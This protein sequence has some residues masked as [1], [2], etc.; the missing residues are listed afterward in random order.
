MI[1]KAS[2]SLLHQILTVCISLV[3]L[4]NG[5]YCKLLNQIPRHQL[6]V[7]RILGNEY[8]SQ[9]TKLI[10]IAEIIMAIWILS[11]FR[12]RI[13]AMLQI[14]II[15]IMNTIEFF[16]AKDLLLFGSWNALWAI[17]LIFVICFNEFHLNRKQEAV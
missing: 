16:L 9:V 17:L 5:F 7:A 4:I 3:W 1:K 6:I 12:S 8:S 2:H 11:R 10:G 13:N 14:A 15:A